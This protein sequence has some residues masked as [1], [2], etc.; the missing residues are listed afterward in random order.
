MSKFEKKM[1]IDP[2]VP[3]ERRSFFKKLGVFALATSVAGGF[4]NIKAK[5]TYSGTEVTLKASDNSL[6]GSIDLFAG[7]F[8]PRAWAFC[9]G[10]LLAISS[11]T[12]L[13]SILG[14]IWGGDGRT[15]FAL[16][17]LRGRTP[18]GPGTGPGLPTYREGERTGALTKILTTFEMPSHNH[19]A[20]ISTP[21]TYTGTI[22]AKTGPGGATADP[23]GAILRNSGADIYSSQTPNANMGANG[24]ELTPVKNAQNNY[25][26]VAVGLTGNQ[27]AISLMQPSLAIHFIICMQGTYP[28]RS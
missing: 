20:V 7:S 4:T 28:S 1:L 17:D 5:N 3:E 2:S 22:T 23:T 11:H 19:N 15:T 27:Q 12:A 9:E 25:G 16:P 14:T 13:F 8:A 21:T 26:N 18:I 24:V 10:Q 6:I